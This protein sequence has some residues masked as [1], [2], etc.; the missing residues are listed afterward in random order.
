MTI[1]TRLERAI[2]INRPSKA[3][4]VALSAKVA[5]FQLL[6]T[7]KFEALNSAPSDDIDTY[8]DSITSSITEAA[9]KTAGNDKAQRPDKLSLVT[10]QLRERRRQMNRNRTDAQHRN[11]A[12]HI[13]YTEICKAIRSRMSEDINNYNEEQLI[14]SL[15]DNKGIKTIKKKQCLGRSNIISL[16]EENGT[17]IHD[18]N[19]MI[20]RCEE[21]YTNLYST[22]LPQGQPSVQI[23]N[24]RSTPPP[25]I[26]PTEVSAPINRPKR[27]KAP[28]N[29]NI[30]TDVLKDGGEPIVQM[31]TN[32]FNRSL[33]EGKLPNSWK[34]A[35]VII[36]HKKGDTADIKNY[37]PISLLPITYKVFS[38][39]ILRRMLCT[40]DQHQPKEQAGF[41]SAFST[42]DHIQVIS[43]L[44]EKADEYKIP[45][46]F[47]FVNY[48][49]SFNSIEFNPLFE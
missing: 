37:R 41:R 9:L 47:A 49:K 43:Q 10:K 33:R 24:T 36:I 28:G 46:G 34:D 27:N 32:M 13:E 14:K 25:P 30:T 3:N 2:L 20:K 31:F 38:Q 17:H 23:H 15:E 1:N 19:R 6:L 40:L 21:F 42:I 12:Q 39:V 8:C 44:Q 22:K 5:E 4:A 7:N 26:L 35:S 29:Y 11:D 48:E 18:R 16:K 45:L